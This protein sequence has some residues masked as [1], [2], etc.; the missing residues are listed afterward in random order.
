[1]PKMGDVLRG[2]TKRVAVQVIRRDVVDNESRETILELPS[3]SMMLVPMPAQ[4]I[5][6]KPEG[7]RKWKWWDCL[8]S[9]ELQLGWYVKTLNDGKKFEVMEKSDWSQAGFFGYQLLEA[10]T[11]AGETA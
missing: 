4:K 2:F 10:P 9:T 5:A 11:A 8:S 1:M 3:I 6:I 7:E